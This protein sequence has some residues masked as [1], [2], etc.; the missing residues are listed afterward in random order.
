MGRWHTREGS[1]DGA[2]SR[3]KML[4]WTHAGNAHELLT[5]GRRE[6]FSGLFVY[7][8]ARLKLNRTRTPDGGEGGSD[9]QRQR[10]NSNSV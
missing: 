7:V 3:R 2:R 10:S 6:R 4:E 9:Q 8:S 5:D 1:S